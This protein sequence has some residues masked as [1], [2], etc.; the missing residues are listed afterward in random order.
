[1]QSQD[2]KQL[3]YLALFIAAASVLQGIEWM[4]PR[5]FP[6]LKL[7]LANMVTLVGIVMYGGRFGIKVAAGRILLSSFLLGTFMTPSFYLSFTGGI[8]AVLIMAGLYRPLGKLSVVGVS[9]CGALAHNLIQILVTYLLFVRHGNILYILPV[10]LIAAVITGGVNGLLVKKIVPS[11]AVFAKRRIFL[12]SGSPRRIKILK[13]AGLPVLAIRPDYE[14]EI[15]KKVEQAEKYALRQARKKVESVASTL[16]PPGCVVAGDTV[17]DLNGEILLKPEN[18]KQAEKMLRLL[19]GRTQ[20]VYTALA[21]K[22]LDKKNDYIIEKIDQTEL[23][24]AEFS[25]EEI[26]KYKKEHQDKAGGYAI[27][28]MKDR[29]V[30]WIKG[31]YTNVVGLPVELLRKLLRDLGI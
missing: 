9:I 21:V 8:G 31:S 24:M 3:A 17:V 16:K 4:L 11:I 13:N 1:M 19:S 2:N 25:E 7:G 14:E 12:A 18:T 15:P 28:G 5:P 23:K 27:Q 30:E 10:I 29:S 22:K 26:E 20:K 6:W